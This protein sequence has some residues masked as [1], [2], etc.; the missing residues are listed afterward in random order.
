MKNTVIILVCG[1]FI[2]CSSTYQI[3]EIPDE[4]L[5]DL[6]FCSLRK[7]V[8]VYTA[9][10]SFTQVRNVHVS[11]DSTWFT[12][13]RKA[14]RFSIPTHQI[15]KI[16]YTDHGKGMMSG[17]YGGV[18]TTAVLTGLTTLGGSNHDGGME[19]LAGPAMLVVGGIYIVPSTSI[20]GYMMGATQSYQLDFAA[21]KMPVT[22]ATQSDSL[23][24]D[25]NAN[26]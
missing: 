23:I 26:E 8:V 20:L 5:D 21:E 16:Q 25:I 22:P 10:D 24:I 13:G 7:D 9:T 4:Q 18:L 14:T 15:V 2:G 12:L 3:R 6:E 11:Y 1:L 17:F 19:D